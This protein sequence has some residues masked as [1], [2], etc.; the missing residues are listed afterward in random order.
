MSTSLPEIS[1]AVFPANI[2]KDAHLRTVPPHDLR[3]LMEY[4][5]SIDRLE[6]INDRLWMA[7][8]PYLPRPLNIQYI[9]SRQV[10]PTTDASLHLLWT[11]KR[12][13]IKALPEYMLSDSFFD[14]HLKQPHPYGLALGFLHTYLAL[15][16]TELDF[17]LAK[18]AKLIPMRYEWTQWRALSR[19]ILDIYP[20]DEIYHRIPQR[21][22]YGELRVSRLDKI[23]RIVHGEW[24]HGYSP[25][26]GHTQY[27]DFLADNLGTITVAT[28]YIVV[29]LSAMQVAQGTKLT[30]NASFQSA[31]YGFAI[32]AIIS[33][34]IALA[35]LLVVFVVMFTTNVLR[36]LAKKRRRLRRLGGGS[37]GVDHYGKDQVEALTA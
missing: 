8:V 4:D 32:F 27:I 20:D 25:L 15:V 16:P 6:R 26:T 5:L 28:V 30:D 22:H 33:P 31:C 13:F 29:V 18:E 1:R 11:A 12:I 19:R 35:L 17:V 14:D 10:V 34:I 3:S 37:S 21:Y 2:P 23:Y 7:G 24:L 36:T 9:M